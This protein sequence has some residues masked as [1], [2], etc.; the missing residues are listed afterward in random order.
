MNLVTGSFCGVKVVGCSVWGV[1]G[2]GNMALNAGM[3]PDTSIFFFKVK[4][5]NIQ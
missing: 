5:E 1:V 3:A 2:G 4:K